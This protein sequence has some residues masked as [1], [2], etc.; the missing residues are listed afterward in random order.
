MYVCMSGVYVWD[1]C[2]CGCGS[3]CVWVCGCGC[4]C[5]GVC[6]CMWVSMCMGDG[7]C[8]RTEK[9]VINVK[10]FVKDRSVIANEVAEYLDIS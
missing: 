2:V 3:M 1:V 7:G 8:S 9:V 6:V 5:V 4:G 10:Q